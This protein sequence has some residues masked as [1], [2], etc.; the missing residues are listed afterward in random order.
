MLRRAAEIVQEV[1]ASATGPGRN[2]A[3]EDYAQA[4]YGL[5][6]DYLRKIGR[7]HKRPSGRVL[8][9]MG[10]EIWVRDPRTGEQEKLEFDYTWDWTP[11]N[12]KP[13]AKTLIGGDYAAA[14]Q[15]S[16]DSD[17]EDTQLSK[18]P[19]PLSGKG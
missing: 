4:K 16:Q 13:R 19:E 10:L 2:A 6:I 3:H 12:P 17:Q 1:L 11:R 18:G 7:V 8:D 15:E 9:N 14:R 5:S